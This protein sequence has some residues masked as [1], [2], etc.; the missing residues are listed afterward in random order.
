MAIQLMLPASAIIYLYIVLY[1]EVV[2]IGRLCPRSAA[3]NRGCGY[4]FLHPPTTNF[5]VPPKRELGINYQ[6]VA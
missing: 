2:E 4:S 3:G 5:Y 6:P 1:F